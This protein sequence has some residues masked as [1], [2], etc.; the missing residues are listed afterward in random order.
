[1]SIGHKGTI[2]AAKAMAITMSDL[3][4]D[5]KLIKNITKE[6]LQRKGDEKY[7][8]MIDGPAPINDN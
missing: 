1:M 5:E 7:E 6:Y 2:Y 8:A 3:Y 4:K